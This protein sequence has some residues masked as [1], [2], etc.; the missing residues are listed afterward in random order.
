MQ[1]KQIVIIGGGPAGLMAA[2]VLKD[3]DVNLAK[4][5]ARRDRKTYM[6]QVEKQ[7]KDRFKGELENLSIDQGHILFKLIDRQTGKDCYSIIRELKGG[8]NAVVWQ[9]VALVFSHNLRKEYDPQGEDKDIEKI[10]LEIEAYY[11]EKYHYQVPGPVV[12]KG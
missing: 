6:K 9:S 11:R 4:M 3:V 7:L 10:V 8:F 2:D 12:K 5:D 1:R